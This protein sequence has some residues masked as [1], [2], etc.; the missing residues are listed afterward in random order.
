VLLTAHPTSFSPISSVNYIGYAIIGG[1]SSMLGPILGSGILVWATNIF[2]IRGEYSQGLFGVLI[3][4]V[5]MLA[6]GGIVGAGV[7]LL[8][9]FAGVRRD[10]LGVSP[11]PAADHVRTPQ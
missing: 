9:R 5:T 2:S 11:K 7:S 8:Q 1:R 10:T 4:V 6:K 3:V